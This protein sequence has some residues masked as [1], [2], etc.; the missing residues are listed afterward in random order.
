MPPVTT[1]HDL[2]VLHGLRVV[3]F[4]DIERLTE[5]TGLN[6]DEVE[7]EL[8]DLA[9]AGLVTRT[10]GPFGG[11]GPTEAGRISDA[12]RVGAELDRTGARDLAVRTHKAFEE[13]N[14]EALDLC[15]AW[16]LR[17]LDGVV[18]ANDHTDPAYDA[19]VLAAFA[20]LE[21]RRDDV[22]ADLALALSRFGRYRVR[23]SEAL[24]RAH[25][26]ELDRVA[27][28]TDSFHTVWSQLHEDL[29]AT[30]GIP[31]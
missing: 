27:D 28:A 13:L 22:C 5:A 26:G 29:L 11:W 24:E 18:T 7:S 31:R 10:P 17:P 15:G 20:D 6:H 2:L 16:Q 25:A 21:R 12:E 14:P 8:I 30:L 4:C 1:P 23:L 3:G 19:R 9:V